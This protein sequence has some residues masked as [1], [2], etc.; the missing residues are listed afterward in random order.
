VSP[1]TGEL[2]VLTEGLDRNCVP[3]PHVREPVWDGDGVL[4]A[5]EDRGDTPLYRVRADGRGAPERVTHGPGAI[6]GFDL[7]GERLVYARSTA[8][9]PGEVWAGDLRLT[10]V[11]RPFREG[12]ALVEPERFV[13]RGADGTEIDAWL[14]RPPGLAAGRRAPVLLSVH[15]GPYTQYGNRFLDEFQVYA[16]AGYAV[17]YCN[18]RGSSG[19]GEEFARAIRVDDEGGG[20]LGTVDADDVGA[21]LDEALRRFDALD[22]ERLGVLGGSYG[23]FMTSWLVG[24]TDRFRAAVSERAVNQWVSFFGSSDEG[25]SFRGYMRSVPYEDARIALRCSPATYAR[26]IRTPLLIL[27][28]EDDLR[29]AVE[30]AQHLF[31]ALRLQR[32]EVEM[33]RFPA[34]GHE[35]SRSGSPVH[36][37]MRFD[38]ILEWFARHLGDGAA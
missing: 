12:R 34:E 2:R 24:H 25:P 30:Q 37:V 26:D 7:A 18:P 19:S 14:V 22:P 21:A 38:V 6:T 35:L 23:G 28:S 13:A 1:E 11:T 17:L 4:F 3:F 31:A 27:H 32:R 9:C 36:R 8:T 5:L 20:G 16:G 15:G 33:V 10:D 29:C